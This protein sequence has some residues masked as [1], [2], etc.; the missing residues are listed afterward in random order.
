M[1]PESVGTLSVLS[2]HCLYMSFVDIPVAF[3]S[4]FRS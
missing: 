2:Y 4:Q 3:I 1:V